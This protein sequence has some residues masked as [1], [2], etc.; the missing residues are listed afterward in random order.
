M[1]HVCAR[2]NLVYNYPIYF[3]KNGVSA[4]P[5]FR[6]SDDV[7]VEKD[8]LIGHSTAAESGGKSKVQTGFYPSR[9]FSNKLKLKE[10]LLD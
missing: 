3:E 4:L 2:Q 6:I 8:T 5:F 10:G 9:T 7:S 1:L